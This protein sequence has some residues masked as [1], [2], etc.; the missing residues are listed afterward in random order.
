MGA[1]DESIPVTL[2]D[3]A[4][5]SRV[6]GLFLGIATAWQVSQAEE[7]TC[8]IIPFVRKFSLVQIRILSEIM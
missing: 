3:A 4:D 5:R 8:F 7:P 1:I 6:G 2:R